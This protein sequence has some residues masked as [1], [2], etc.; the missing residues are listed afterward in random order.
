MWALLAAAAPCLAAL[1][2]SAQ[3]PGGQTLS[4]F[5]GEAMRATGRDTNNRYRKLDR[6]SAFRYDPPPVPECDAMVQYCCTPGHP[7]CTYAGGLSRVCTTSS[8]WRKITFH[9]VL[10][11]CTGGE[12]DPVMC[13]GINDTV[14][15]TFQSCMLDELTD[16]AS[17]ESCVQESCTDDGSCGC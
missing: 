10:D 16:L 5:E 1:L 3:T 4:G 15:P 12:P 7:P 13:A 11:L 9:D 2:R 17:L 6:L 8:T 14:I